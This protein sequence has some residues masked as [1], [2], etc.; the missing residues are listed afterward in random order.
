MEDQKPVENDIVEKPVEMVS[1]EDK[2]ASSKKIILDKPT[3]LE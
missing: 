1:I 2:N 3:W